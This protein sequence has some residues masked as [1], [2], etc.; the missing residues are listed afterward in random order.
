MEDFLARVR[1]NLDAQAPHLRPLFD[2]MAGEAR[3]ARA[4]LDEDLKRL[5][6]AAPILEL[7]GGVFLLACQLSREGFAVTAIEPTGVGFGAFE[8]LGAAVLAMAAGDGVVPTIARCKAEEFRSDA[9]F[10]LAFSVN[11]MEHID[12]PDVAMARVSA[13]LS[14]GGSHRFLCPNYLFPYE[15]HFNIPTLGSKALTERLLRR[16]IEGNTRMDD[17][18]GVWKSLNWITVPQVRRIAAA[19]AS[20]AIAFHSRTLAWMIERVVGD[21]EFAKRRAAWMVAAIK[22]LSTSRL[23]RFASLVPATCQPLMDVRLTKLH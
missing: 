12:A 4:W 11:V 8:E 23:L 10:A 18:A 20:L 5:P 9:R 6:E 2:V 16:R 22:V 1:Q 21:V 3:F 17:P 13:V 7:G 15:P 19:D 14:P